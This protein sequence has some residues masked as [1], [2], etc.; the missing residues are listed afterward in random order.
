MSKPAE[1]VA[2]WL[3]RFAHPDWRSRAQHLWRAVGVLAGAVCF[4]LALWALHD[5]LGLYRYRDIAEAL[6][7]I[8]GTSL[9]AALALTVLASVVVMGYD[10]LAVRFIR[11]AVPLRR[12]A[13]AAFVSSA[14]S[15]NIGNAL[16][17]GGPV[18]YW[19][20]RP[21]GLTAGDIARIVIFCSLGFWLGF[22]AVA[23][24]LF[25]ALALEIPAAL[26]LPFATTRP[27]GTIL[28]AVLALYVVAVATMPRGLKRFSWTTMVPSTRLTAGQLCI[29][30][31][32]V[33][34]MA[35]ALYV[36]L[37][38]ESLAY[39]EWLPIFLLALIA[40]ASSQ[41]PGG[42]G[43]F[44]AVVLL[45]VAPYASLPQSAAALL[46]FRFLYSILPL[47][48]ATGIITV[49][50]LGKPRHWLQGVLSGVGYR[51]ERRPSSHVAGA[52]TAED[53]ERVR[54]IVERSLW[55]YANL[56]YRGD[57]SLIVSD[58]GKAFLMYGH[59]HHTCVAMGDPVGPPEESREL[60][61]RFCELCAKTGRRPVFFEVR[62]D[63]AK[64]YRA[65]GLTLTKLGEEA[66]VD[67][68]RFDIRAHACAELRQA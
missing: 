48:I 62:E 3:P 43:V 29:G 22:F 45:L 12:V 37:P 17:T 44:E 5:T 63:N 67:L 1:S 11:R 32:D 27:L 25:S 58:S 34:T 6:S 59:I 49:R 56:V 19:I 53:L 60:A 65:L 36:L 2:R 14:F 9:F 54:P 41:V 4:A 31:L 52:A 51:V 46:A 30:T 23:G 47:I 40:G 55:T 42:L 57:K 61:S 68:A 7:A 38:H 21:L 20:Y 33:L 13:L 66:R 28:L 24:L 50:Q 64:I 18:R 15:N 26:H 8:P 16:L 35:T 10:A 39:A